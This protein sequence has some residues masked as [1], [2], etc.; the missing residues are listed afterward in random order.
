MESLQTLRKNFDLKMKFVSIVSIIELLLTHCPDS[1]RYNVEDSINRQF[2]NKV[3]LICHLY[4]KSSNFELITKECGHIYSLR[5]DVAHG[6]FNKFP[7][8]LE[9]Y[10]SFCKENNYTTIN[11]FDKKISFTYNNKDYELEELIK[12]LNLKEKTRSYKENTN[13]NSEVFNWC[14]KNLDYKTLIYHSAIEMSFLTKYF[15]Y[16]INLDVVWAN[17]INGQTSFFVG[18]VK[19]KSKNKNNVFIMN[20]GEK[21]LYE[22]ILK[23]TNIQVVAIALV[24]DKKDRQAT[25]IELMND[26]NFPIFYKVLK[27]NDFIDMTI[28]LGNLSDFDKQ[29]GKKQQETVDFAFKDFERVLD[30]SEIGKDN[31]TFIRT[32]NKVLVKYSHL[33]HGDKK[34]CQ[35]HIAKFYALF[36]MMKN[37]FNIDY[38]DYLNEN[39]IKENILIINGYKVLFKFVESYRS[40]NVTLEQKEFDIAKEKNV[41][42]ILVYQNTDNGKDVLFNINQVKKNGQVFY[43]VDETTT[44]NVIKI[45][46]CIPFKVFDNYK[47][48]LKA[49]IP[50]SQINY[51]AARNLNGYKTNM[52]DKNHKSNQDTYFLQILGCKRDGSDKEPKECQLEVYD[53]TKNLPFISSYVFY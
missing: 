42:F 30:F 52:N 32:L 53:K 47:H 13:I 6:N 48:C 21:I 45:L 15:D 43:L 49:G 3:A 19:F 14:Y 8:D 41:D 23:K 34:Y 9:R 40:W 31:K 18:E 7:K 28:K 46:G 44:N 4:D 25:L 38:N 1:T 51:Y 35:K 50:K 20:K 12:I 17:E 27:E 24:C 16:T 10:Y 5:S 39:S 22:T 26:N 2:K 29:N 33:L 37:G 36:D 11:E